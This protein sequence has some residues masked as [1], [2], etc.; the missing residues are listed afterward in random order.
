MFV[1]RVDDG[2]QE[3]AVAHHLVQFLER[4]E[5]KKGQVKQKLGANA[6]GENLPDSSCPR[7]LARCPAGKYRGRCVA[8]T[9]RQRTAELV[10]QTAWLCRP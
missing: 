3:D 2:P 6:D 1:R 5:K 10:P 8:R 9:W 4:N 7:T